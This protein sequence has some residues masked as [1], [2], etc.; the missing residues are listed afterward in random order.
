LN[1]SIGEHKE[2]RIG[3]KFCNSLS[4]NQ[5]DKI[6]FPN[7]KTSKRTMRQIS[8]FPLGMRIMKTRIGR[9]VNVEYQM[10]FI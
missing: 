1:T 10:A 8:T 7:W 9:A 4:D 5:N 6:S 3:R 2:K